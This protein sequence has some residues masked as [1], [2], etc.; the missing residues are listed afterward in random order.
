MRRVSKR[1]VLR[2]NPTPA[3]EKREDRR[4]GEG[5]ALVRRLLAETGNLLSRTVRP[6]PPNLLDR[7]IINSEGPK[8]WKVEFWKRGC[9]STWWKME[10]RGKSRWRSAGLVQRF[11][12]S[13]SKHAWSITFQVLEL[14]LELEIRVDKLLVFALEAKISNLIM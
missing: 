8:G 1:K 6:L 10:L 14:E 13:L 5:D 12:V 4:D 11:L 7:L 3:E 2:R 9:C